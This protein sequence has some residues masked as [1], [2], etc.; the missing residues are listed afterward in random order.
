MLKSL[1]MNKKN[2]SKLKNTFFG[3]NLYSSSFAPSPKERAVSQKKY[4]QKKIIKIFH[5]FRHQKNDI[6]QKIEIL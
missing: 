2:N 3:Y 1:K 6:I 4:H 5:F